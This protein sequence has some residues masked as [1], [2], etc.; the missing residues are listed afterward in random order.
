MGIGEGEPHPAGS[1]SSSAE[2]VDVLRRGELVVLGRIP[3]ASNATLVCDV[4]L[5]DVELR[6]VYKPVRG[7]VPLWDFPDGTL[8]GREVA[9]Y[10]ISDA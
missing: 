1:G 4:V 5:D 7:E 2:V 10:L 9:S 6:C 8:A 3:S